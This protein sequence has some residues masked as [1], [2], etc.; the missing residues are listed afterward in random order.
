ML[1][2]RKAQS[3]CGC[4]SIVLERGHKLEQRGGITHHLGGKQLPMPKASG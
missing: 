1:C 4:C 3:P 2:K